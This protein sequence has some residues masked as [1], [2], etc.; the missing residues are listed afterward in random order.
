VRLQLLQPAY[1]CFVQLICL[2]EKKKRRQKNGN[3][4]GLGCNCLKFL[5][6]KS[7]QALNQIEN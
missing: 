7:T 5:L 4:K 1:F 3:Q 2:E 6:D